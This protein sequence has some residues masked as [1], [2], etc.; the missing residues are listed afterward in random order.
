M[1]EL[2]QPQLLCDLCADLEE[3][4]KEADELA[5]PSRVVRVL[6]RILHQLNMLSLSVLS[7]HFAVTKTVG[8]CAGVHMY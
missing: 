2:F 4:G 8:F 3:G 7:H 1:D 6:L 5:E